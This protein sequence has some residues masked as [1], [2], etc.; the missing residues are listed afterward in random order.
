MKNMMARVRVP[1]ERLFLVSKEKQIGRGEK[2]VKIISKNRG[3]LHIS[4]R[5]MHFHAVMMTNA[6][7]NCMKYVRSY[8]RD[9]LFYKF[10]L[11]RCVT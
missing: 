10:C 9:D 1:F 2:S 7:E 6:V 11:Y 4:H 5:V 3:Q 8:A